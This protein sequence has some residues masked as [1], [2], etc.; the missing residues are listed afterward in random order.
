MSDYVRRFGFGRRA[1]PDFPGE[2]PGIVWN[3][4]KLTDSALASVSMGYQVGVTPLQM[5]TAVSSVANGG[6]LLEPRVVRAVIRDGKRIPVPRKVVN[7]SITPEIA[8]EMT[9][10]MEGVVDRGTATMAQIPGYTIAGK[11]GTAAKL[12]GGRYSRSDYNGSFVGFLPSQKPALTI[13]V[14]TD[15][16]HGKNGYYGGPVSGPVFKRIAEAALRYYGVPPTLNAPP[17]LLLTRAG[18]ADDQPTA[19][20]SQPPAILAMASASNAG[21]PVFPDL[22]GMNARDAVRLLSRLGVTAKLHGTGQVSEQRPA[23]GS[24]LDAGADAALWLQRDPNVQ[25]VSNTP[26]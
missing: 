14:V 16:A 3:P 15:S 5:A 4:A 22:T 1:S 8:V 12:V 24:P 13:V 18:T 2:T 17:P 9:T 23:A 7:R 6:E 10:I 11:T 26:Q 20:I 25:L 21:M 19:A